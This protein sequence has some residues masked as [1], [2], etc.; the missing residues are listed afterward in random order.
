MLE[1]QRISIPRCYK[2]DDFG[3]VVSAQLHHFLDASVK[4]YGQCSYLR[5]VDENQS[6]LLLCYGK[7][8]SGTIE[9]CN[10]TTHGAYHHCVLS[11]NQ[12]AVATS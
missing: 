5:L 11:E 8:Q 1:V 4:G 10:Y 7:V 6:S 12:T 2:P 9:A 3:R